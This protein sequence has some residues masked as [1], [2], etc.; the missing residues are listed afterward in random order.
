MLGVSPGPSDQKYFKCECGYRGSDCHH[1][2]I[3]E[4]NVGTPNLAQ[5]CS[6][7]GAAWLYLSR[8]GHIMEAEGGSYEGQGVWGQGYSKWMD[9]HISMLDLL[10]VDISCVHPAEKTARKNASEQE[11][12]AAAAP[13]KRMRKDHAQDDTPGYKLVPFSI[14]SY[15]RMGVEADMLL[16]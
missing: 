1:A 10:M 8:F 2:M 9:V 12:A 4:K 16:T 14:E 5:P 11:G 15:R 6:N 13:D 7:I 3:C